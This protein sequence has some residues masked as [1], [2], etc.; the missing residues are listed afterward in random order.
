MPNIALFPPGTDCRGI[1]WLHRRWPRV[2]VRTWFCRIEAIFRISLCMGSSY[3]FNWKT[4]D[5]AV[6]GRISSFSS[7]GKLSTGIGK[8]SISGR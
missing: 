8:N 3:W 6:L 1:S 2:S 5:E 4:P 7:D